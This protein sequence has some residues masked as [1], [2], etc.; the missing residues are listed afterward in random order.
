MQLSDV[1]GLGSSHA[2]SRVASRLAPSR[3]AS[4]NTSSAMFSSTPVMRMTSAQCLQ[5][6]MRRLPYWL[7]QGFLSIQLDT[8]MLHA[9]WRAQQQAGEQGSSKKS[10][11]IPFSS[12]KEKRRQRVTWVAWPCARASGTG[13]AA[14]GSR[15]WSSC[16]HGRPATPSAPAVAQKMLLVPTCLRCVAKP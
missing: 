16:S 9:A 10:H 7:I 4:L 15:R 12:G 2:S 1:R 11:M 8:G 6:G 5:T 13:A 3:C 14:P